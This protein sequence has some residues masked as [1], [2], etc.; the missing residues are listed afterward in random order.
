VTLGIAL[1]MVSVMLL[2]IDF[3]T[4]AGRRY[5]PRRPHDARCSGLTGDPV[6]VT[7]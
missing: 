2:T 4:A 6:V 7:I 1:L 3:V 5:W